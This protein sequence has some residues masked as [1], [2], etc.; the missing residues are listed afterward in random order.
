MLEFKE[1]SSEARKIELILLVLHAR[2]HLSKER[3]EWDGTYL[4]ATLSAEWTMMTSGTH[5]TLIFFSVEAVSILTGN[6]IGIFSNIC[7]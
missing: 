2:E 7:R 6:I 5:L 4:W 1:P 3:F